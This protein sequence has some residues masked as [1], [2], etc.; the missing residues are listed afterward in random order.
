VI[1]RLERRA[2]SSSAAW[3]RRPAR[4]PLA[5]TDEGHAVLAAVIPAMRRTQERILQPL[6]AAER[7]EFMRMLQIL[8]KANNALSRAPS[9]A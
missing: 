3:I 6:P 2:A 8:V 4:A 7:A 9:E 5:L 1:D